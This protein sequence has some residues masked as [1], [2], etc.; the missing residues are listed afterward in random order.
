MLRGTSHCQEHG[1]GNKM[2]MLTALRWRAALVEEKLGNLGRTGRRRQREARPQRGPKLSRG[3]ARKEGMPHIYVARATS[4]TTGQRRN[5]ER[6]P[7][8]LER[9]ASRH[10]HHSPEAELEPGARA[11]FQI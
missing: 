10:S 5:A 6:G 3:W 4:P 2:D 9:P 1:R 11:K 7:Q 8:H